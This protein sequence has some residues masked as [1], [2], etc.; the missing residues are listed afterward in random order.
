MS[1]EHLS[2]DDLSPQDRLAAGK[3]CR[4]NNALFET[5]T[6][7][8][9]RNAIL[10]DV[11]TYVYPKLIRSGW[12][13]AAVPGTPGVRAAAVLYGLIL[14]SNARGRTTISYDRLGLLCGYSDDSVAKGIRTLKEMGWISVVSRGVHRSNVTTL[15]SKAKQLAFAFYGL[16]DHA[17]DRLRAHAQSPDNPAPQPQEEGPEN[18]ARQQQKTRKNPPPLSGE[19][20]VYNLDTPLQGEVVSTTETRNASLSRTAKSKIEQPKDAEEPLPPPPTPETTIGL[21]AATLADFYDSPEEGIKEGQTALRYMRQGN[22]DLSRKIVR[23]VIENYVST[24]QINQRKWAQAVEKHGDMAPLLVCQVIAQG[25][26]RGE[27]AP[28][29]PIRSVP[30]YILGALSKDAG[31]LRPDVTIARIWEGRDPGSAERRIPKGV[32]DDQLPLIPTGN[33]PQRVGYSGSKPLRIEKKSGNGPDSLANEL[34]RFVAASDPNLAGVIQLIREVDFDD[35]G[36]ALVINSAWA[37]S[38]IQRHTVVERMVES[39]IRAKGLTV[40]SFH[41]RVD[42]EGDP[43]GFVSKRDPKGRAK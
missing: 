1:H 29:K 38:Q 37:K 3:R 5:R 18:P 20:P 11:R 35:A 14:A 26:L 30:R 21:C 12:E 24:W 4:G 13:P 16:T 33:L 7:R 40:S 41:F 6:G 27:R 9:S 8:Q 15:A 10:Q 31:E 34:H 23:R 22:I 19:N 28:V 25:R 42:K 43:S 32:P 2:D 36:M 39:W 17:P